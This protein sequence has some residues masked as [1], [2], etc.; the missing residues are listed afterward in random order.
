MSY[1]KVN[2]DDDSL[3]LMNYGKHAG[4]ETND[5][6][7]LKYFFDDKIISSIQS[8]LADKLQPYEEQKR[9]VIVDKEIIIN[10][11]QS[12]I[13]DK[14]P[15]VGDIHTRYLMAN[16][17]ETFDDIKKQTIEIIYSTLKNEMEIE[18]NNA[19]LSVW[20]TLYGDFNSQGLRQH[21]PVKIRKNTSGMQFHMKY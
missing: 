2:T 12:V 14:R 7:Y 9:R 8:F 13:N 10:T 3:K 5:K 11:M 21:P 1:A 15:I 16:M 18:A 6:E 4:Y 20:N 19:N 17:D